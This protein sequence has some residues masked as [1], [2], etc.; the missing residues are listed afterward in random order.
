MQVGHSTIPPGS[1]SQQAP[2]HHPPVGLADG[3]LCSV[4]QSEPIILDAADI[5]GVDQEGLVNTQKKLLRELAGHSVQ[6][7]TAHQFMLD[8]MNG[9]P[10]MVAF[11]IAYGLGRQGAGRPLH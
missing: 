4:V 6:L 9:D 10:L 3:Q 5:Q 2:P 1:P 8:G 11:N 7:V